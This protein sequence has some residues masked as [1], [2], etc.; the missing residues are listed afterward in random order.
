[1]EWMRRQL[2][3]E[4]CNFGPFKTSASQ[5]LEPESSLEFM[6]PHR[7]GEKPGLGKVC[8]RVLQFFL[9]VR[10]TKHN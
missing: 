7:C 3:S 2:K 8:A 6:Q 4:E 5:S 9:L 1:M 10:K